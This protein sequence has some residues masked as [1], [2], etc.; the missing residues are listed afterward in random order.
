[1]AMKIKDAL[2]SQ[3]FATDADFN[4][5]ESKWPSWVQYGHAFHCDAGRGNA[6]QTMARISVMKGVEMPGW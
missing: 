4:K 3:G 2:I 5:E 6:R 1:M